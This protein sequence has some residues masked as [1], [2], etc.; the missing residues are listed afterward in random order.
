[1]KTRG[2]PK[3]AY[4]RPGSRSPGGSEGGAGSHAPLNAI[5][6]GTSSSTSENARKNGVGGRL[7]PTVFVGGLLIHETP[8]VPARS[9]PNRFLY[10]PENGAHGRGNGLRT[11]SGVGGEVAGGKRNGNAHDVGEDLLEHDYGDAGRTEVGVSSMVLW[12]RAGW[13]GVVG[14]L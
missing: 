9:G 1:M 3:P 10:D 14:E 13:V 2:S 4:E 11:G 6:K 5:G 12:A 8:G 7:P